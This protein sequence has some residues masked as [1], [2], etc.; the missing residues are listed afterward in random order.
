MNGDL[1][2]CV[3]EACSSHRRGMHN[4]PMQSSFNPIDSL[5]DDDDDDDDEIYI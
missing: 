4:K 2:A 1:C 3:G 5:D